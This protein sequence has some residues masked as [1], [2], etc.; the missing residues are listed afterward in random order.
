MSVEDE[1]TED[2]IA[3]SPAKKA[4]KAKAAKTA[5]RAKKKSSKKGT[6]AG[7]GGA[8]TFPR[9]TIEKALRIPKAI[10]DQNA[11][12]NCSERDSA[13]YVGVG[14]NGP[15][16]VE[17][18]SALKYGL[19]SRPESGIL[20]V[21]DRARQA[22]RP[23]KP[24]DDI[25]ALRQAVLDAPQISEVYKHYRGEYLP[26]GT[27]F[28]HALVDK[29]NI[30]PEKVS[31]FTEIFMA[32]LNSAR[33]LERKD[34]KYR[35]LDVTSSPDRE[36]VSELKRSAGVKIAA[37]DTCF[38]VMPFAAPVGGYFQNIYEPAIHK[39]GLR[40]VRADADIFGTGKIIDQ[41]WSGINAAKVLVAELTTRNP[42]VF[43]ELG[44]AHAL[45]KPVVL[46]SSN[47]EDVPFDLKHIRVIYYDVNDPFW[48]QK[49]IDKVAENIVS[50]LKNPE[51]AVFKRALESK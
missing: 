14:F 5:K 29:F 21:T 13:T 3:K 12:R 16:R 20:A 33:L 22:I 25:D 45:D 15:Y 30:P 26:D 49:L 7:S 27:F 39:A 6:G 43:Y 40:A 1:V 48:G 31:E 37:G 24:G 50:A 4:K 35:V 42:N 46:V 44:L 36:T 23:Q 34:D 41:I 2:S 19:L 38:V 9:H 32:T 51:E 10:I 28:E 8:A 11:G 17:I 18:S 47:E